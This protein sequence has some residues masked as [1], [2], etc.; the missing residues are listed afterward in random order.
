MIL[1]EILFTNTHLSYDA[2]HPSNS[3][4][5]ATQTSTSL[6]CTPVVWRSGETIASRQ[7]FE[8]H[9]SMKTVFPYI[10]SIILT[11]WR[12]WNF[13]V[14]F[15]YN[16]HLSKYRDFRF[17]VFHD[18]RETVTSL[19]WK[20]CSNA[21]PPPPPHVKIGGKMCHYIKQHIFCGL[22]PIITTVSLML[23]ITGHCFPIKCIWLADINIQF[24][25][26]L[27]CTSLQCSDENLHIKLAY[28]LSDLN[29]HTT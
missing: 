4:E 25:G 9:L 12:S 1:G 15:W 22:T 28:P 19:E 20:F 2:K 16:D 26:Q 8:C 14:P 27:S 13:R 7:N 17:K 18:V 6:M 29:N 11:M 3:I 5:Q 21:P 10:G 23:V 24:D